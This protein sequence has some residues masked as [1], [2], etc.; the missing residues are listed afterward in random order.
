MPFTLY[1]FVDKKTKS[2][3]PPFFI[4]SRVKTDLKHIFT[5]SGWARGVAYSLS[6]PT[7]SNILSFYTRGANVG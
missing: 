7:Y 2:L 6:F 4:V 3:E 1:N 5:V